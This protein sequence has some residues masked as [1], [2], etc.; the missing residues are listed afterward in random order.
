VLVFVVDNLRAYLGSDRGVAL[1]DPGTAPYLHGLPCA[2][3]SIM[4]SIVGGGRGYVL[5]TAAVVVLR[6]GGCWMALLGRGWDWGWD[7]GTSTG[8]GTGSTGTEHRHRHIQAHMLFFF[9]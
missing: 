1:G 2:R 6:W 8:T 3:I 4:C 9:T 5:N 7:A